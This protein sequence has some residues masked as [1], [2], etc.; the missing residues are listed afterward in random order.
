MSFVIQCSQ[1]AAR[2][3]VAD[4]ASGK[5]VRC[6]QCGNNFTAA[7]MPSPAAPDPLWSA[8][9]QASPPH[10]AANPSQ[11][12]GYATWPPPP[13]GWSPQ[14]PGGVNYGVSNPSGG[15]TDSTMRIVSGVMLALG[16]IL[17]L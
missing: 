12:T 5:I 17:C 1:C 8:L 15:P 13:A 4:G 3:Q 2:Y 11:A 10:P 14:L 16:V 9:P 6:G 7:P